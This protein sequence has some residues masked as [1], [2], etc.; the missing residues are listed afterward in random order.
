VRVFGIVG[1]KDSGKTHLVVRLVRHLRGQGLAVATVKHTHHHAPQVDRP[2]SDSARHFEAGAVE[3]VLASD[4]GWVLFHRSAA[5]PTLDAIAARIDPC[6]LLLVEG[7]KQ[8]ESL[9]RLEVY[10]PAGTAPEPAGE[11]PPPAP[12]LAFSDSGIAAIA[13]PRDTPAAGWPTRLAR[14]D[15]DDTAAIAAFVLAHARD[16][17]G[18]G[19]VA[20]SHRRGPTR[21]ET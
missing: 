7:Y 20:G 18:R 1:R 3:T 15:L 6:D 14:L 8:L 16:A 5:P 19:A 9:A 4:T 17:D 10:R 21:V 2:G 11:A 13:C 12:P